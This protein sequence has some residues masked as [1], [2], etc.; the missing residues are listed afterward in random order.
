MK[1]WLIRIAA[2]IVFGVSFALPAIRPADAGAS[3]QPIAGWTCA[4]FASILAPKA[5]A[6]SIGQG[7]QRDAILVPASGLVNYLFLFVLVLSFWRRLLRTRLIVGALMIPCFIGTW[8]FFS[9]SKITPLAGHYLWVA[10]AVLLVVPDLF[11]LFF[12]QSTAAGAA[13]ESAAP[14]QVSS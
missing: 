13:S 6:S 11:G 7:V 1:A 3:A 2:L 8:M 12:K 4:L 10:G 9:T 14:T 5:L